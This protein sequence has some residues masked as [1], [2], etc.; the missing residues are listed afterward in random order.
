MSLPLFP[1]APT[2]AT[3]VSV[4]PLTRAELLVDLDDLSAA[5]V[6]HFATQPSPETCDLLARMVL[7]IAQTKRLVGP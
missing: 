1:A 2:G 3:L 6:Q 4:R 7:V 5:C